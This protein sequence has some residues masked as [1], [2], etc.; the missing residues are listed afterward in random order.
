MHLEIAE[1]H[2]PLFGHCDLVDL[3]LVSA[4]IVSYM[5]EVGTPLV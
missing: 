4:I 1:R 5:I 2:V 3:D